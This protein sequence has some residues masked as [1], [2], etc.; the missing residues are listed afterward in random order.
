MKTFR[1]LTSRA[2]TANVSS[3]FVGEG[4]R[5]LAGSFVPG[6][7]SDMDSLNESI[8]RRGWPE[9]IELS[10]SNFLDGDVAGGVTGRTCDHMD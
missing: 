8:E 7:E 3:I 1:I 4:L 2:G 10:F 9:S 5:R 6:G